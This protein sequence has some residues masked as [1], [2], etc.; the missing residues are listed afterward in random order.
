MIDALPLLRAVKR[1]SAP[2][3]SR[4]VSRQAHNQYAINRGHKG[5]SKE[6]DA[7]GDIGCSGD[8]GVEIE[9]ATIAADGLRMEQIDMEIADRLYLSINSVKTYV[10]TADAKIGAHSRSQAVAGCL[11]VGFAPPDL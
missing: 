10:R 7:V 11:Q 4:P 3:G 6:G 1:Y 9:R 5:F 2:D 8:R